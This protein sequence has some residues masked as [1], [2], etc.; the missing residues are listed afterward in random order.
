MAP[1]RRKTSGVSEDSDISVCDI[2]NS[3]SSFGRKAEKFMNITINE[4][5]SFDDIINHN[6]ANDEKISYCDDDINEGLKDLF[7]EG[8]NRDE[9]RVYK[10]IQ[11][12]NLPKKAQVFLYKLSTVINNNYQ[13]TEPQHVEDYIHELMDN[14]LKEAEFEDGTELILMPCVL[15]LLIGSESFAAHSD[16]EGRRGTEIIWVLDKD[17][18]KFDKRWRK[19]DIQLIA[20]MVAAAQT[21]KSL[22]GK[23]YPE[24]VIGIKFDA[25]RLYF[26]SAYVTEEY[27]NELLEDD[28]P[29]TELV[30]N[31]FPKSR[32]LSLSFCKDRKEIFLYLSALKKYALSLEPIYAE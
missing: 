23:V 26:Y 32:E 24:R 31:K 29:K 16:K 28:G 19:G 9:V 10:P 4:A 14:V 13:P 2:G 8:F 3:T 18:H 30:V 15:R 21:N 7:L 6:I 11:H 1:K 12:K 20:N 25:D 5:D 22:L 17:K 27:L